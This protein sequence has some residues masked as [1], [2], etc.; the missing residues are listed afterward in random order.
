MITKTCSKCNRRLSLVSFTKHKL[1]KDGLSSRCKKCSKEHQK[2]FR[3]SNKELLKERTRGY[4]LKRKFK[5]TVEEYDSMLLSQKGCCAICKSSECATGR[6][7]S[8]DHCHTTG[9]IRG[10]L[11]QSCNTA[12]GKLKDDINVL[13]EAV[14]YLRRF[15]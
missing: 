12:L 3:E 6:R 1:S 14:K 11:C 7:L 10:L 9:I 8:V 5:L 2:K 4:N 13:K 15:K